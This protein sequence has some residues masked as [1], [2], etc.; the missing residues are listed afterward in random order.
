MYEG[1][2][3]RCRFMGERFRGGYFLRKRKIFKGNKLEGKEICLVDI[4]GF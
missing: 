3:C 1:L 4:G 2:F